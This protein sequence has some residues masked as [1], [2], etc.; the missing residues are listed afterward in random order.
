MKFI[1][2]LLATVWVVTLAWILL[3]LMTWGLLTLGESWTVIITF[4]TA[5]SLQVGCF[6]GGNRILQV[7]WPGYTNPAALSQFIDDLLD[8]PRF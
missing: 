3:P 2:K 4:P 7:I 8:T 6:W 5:L 1:M